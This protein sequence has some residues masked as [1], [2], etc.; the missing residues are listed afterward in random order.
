M[1]KYEDSLSPQLLPIYQN[2]VKERMQIS[3]QG[4]AIGFF[5]SLA[6]LIYNTKIRNVPLSTIPTLCSFIFISYIVNHLYYMIMPKS[7]HM[8]K[9]LTKKE[10]ID[11][12]LTM[13]DF[14]KTQFHISF[15]IGLVALAIYFFSFC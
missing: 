13:Y 2:I 9:H 10:E 7:D 1:K 14:M 3:M 6:F 15:A 8:L 4:Y 12:W 5:L 11:A